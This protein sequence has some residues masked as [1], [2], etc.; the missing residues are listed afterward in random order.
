MSLFNKFLDK[1]IH[2]KRSHTNGHIRETDHVGASVDANEFGHDAQPQNEARSSSISG[3][4]TSP[5]ATTMNAPMD[6]TGV[7]NNTV[8]NGNSM[9]AAQTVG[10]YGSNDR[11]AQPHQQQPQAKPA[12]SPFATIDYNTFFNGHGYSH[13]DSSKTQDT[14]RNAPSTS[15]TTSAATSPSGNIASLTTTSPLQASGTSHSPSGN[16]CLWRRYS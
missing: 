9:S 15:A 5:A 1:T 2:R 11:V 12:S 6:Y 7:S 16:N 10:F 4:N 8:S 14:F 13:D 3:L